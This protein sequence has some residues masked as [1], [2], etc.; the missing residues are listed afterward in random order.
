M[1]V[2][3]PPTHPDC[4][5]FRFCMMI[6]MPRDRTAEMDG[7]HEETIGWIITSL[8]VAVTHGVVDDINKVS[9]IDN[10]EGFDED[11]VDD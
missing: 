4:K 6:V 9:G 8:E 2:K 3:L 1:D 5:V 10:N 11:S 7:C